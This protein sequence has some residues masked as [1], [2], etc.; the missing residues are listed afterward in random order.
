MAVNN[1]PLKTKE[2]T[3]EEK[4]E[5]QKSSTFTENQEEK[6]ASKQ[7]EHFIKTKEKAALLSRTKKYIEAGF[8]V[9][10]TGPSGVGKTSMALELARQFEQPVMLLHGNHE[11]SNTDL[12]GGFTGYTSKK[13]IDNYVRTVYK[14]EENL[15]EQ[16]S[17]GRLM[18]AVK[19]GYTVVYDEFTRSKPETNN[20]FL[21]VLEEGVL[22]LY[23]MKQKDSFIRVHPNFKV[24][25][26]SNPKE[27]VGVYH[28]Q[29]ALMDRL[30]TIPI[31]NEDEKT[32][33]RMLAK[34]TNLTSREAGIIVTFISRIRKTCE[35]KK[36]QGPSFRT[37]VMIA[38]ICKKNNIS[39]NNENNTFADVCSDMVSAYV[40]KCKGYE[41]QNK[42]ERLIK[43]ELK[44]TG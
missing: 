34:K 3:D 27:F 35:E 1:T 44:K 28:T 23:G 6:D 16:W 22:P 40:M 10:F 19:K 9:H 4:N 12:L 37:A 15:T 11:L 5:Y 38:E 21:S 13:V 33:T 24:I 7:E 18:E 17:P 36:E 32:E 31:E 29:D 25:F 8:P 41:N 14:K 2:K 42:A 43:Q 20:L 30:I 26:T 39:I